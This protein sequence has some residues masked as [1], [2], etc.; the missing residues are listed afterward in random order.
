M[1][2]EGYGDAKSSLNGFQMAGIAL[3]ILWLIGATYYFKTEA[4]DQRNQV[5]AH[6]S[7]VCHGRVVAKKAVLTTPCDKE[8]SEAMKKAC[9][10]KQDEKLASLEELCAREVGAIKSRYASSDR[11]MELMAKVILPVPVFWILG[12]VAFRLCRWYI[13]DH[14]PTE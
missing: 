12:L 14:Q 11:Q 4:D 3:S 1:G 8:E 7:E 13:N 6:A 2:G 10:H 5:I 9:Q